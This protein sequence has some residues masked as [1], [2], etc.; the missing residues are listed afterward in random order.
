MVVQSPVR[1]W[2]TGSG[3]PAAQSMPK[4]RA[5]GTEAKNDVTSTRITRCRPVWAA[6]KLCGDRPGT[7]PWAAS[8]VGIPLSSSARTLR[9]N[10][11]SRYL[12]ASTSRPLSHR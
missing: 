9:C 4:T 11:F 6:A 7:K 12:G 3:K 5:A 10:A 2:A 8:W 1:V